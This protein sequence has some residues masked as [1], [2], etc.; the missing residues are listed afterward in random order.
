MIAL[1]VL[2]FCLVTLTSASNQPDWFSPSDDN[3]ELLK[4]VNVHRNEVLKCGEM[5]CEQRSKHREDLDK[6]ESD[7]E[8]VSEE[9]KKD[10]CCTEWKAEDCVYALFKSDA[11]CTELIKEEFERDINKQPRMCSLKYARGGVGCK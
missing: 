3:Q 10:V 2:S 5:I 6:H 7:R 8:N 9:T 4:C 1:I 11:K